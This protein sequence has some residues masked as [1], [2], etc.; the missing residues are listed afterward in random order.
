MSSPGKRMRVDETYSSNFISAHWIL[1]FSESA[2]WPLRQSTK[3]TPE[4][5]GAGG[6]I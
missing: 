2:A 1:S 4:P 5:G 6:I 3:S